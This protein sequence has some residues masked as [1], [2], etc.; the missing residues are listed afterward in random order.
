MI[1]FP[2]K[3]IQSYVSYIWITFMPWNWRVFF[4]FSVC[5]FCNLN[6]FL[7]IEF[8]FFLLIFQVFI[9]NIIFFYFWA[10]NFLDFNWNKLVNFFNFFTFLTFWFFIFYFNFWIL[11]ISNLIA[12]LFGCFL[13]ISNIFISIFL[14]GLI[15]FILDFIFL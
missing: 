11:L 4:L 5:S 10:F 8:L 2:F 15:F 7:F 12:I 13:L 9:N 3:I 14:L 6:K 1:F